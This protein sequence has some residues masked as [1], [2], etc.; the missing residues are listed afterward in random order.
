MDYKIEAGYRVCLAE[1]DPKERRIAEMFN[2]VAGRYDALNTVLS[3]GLD[4]SWRSYLISKISPQ[5]KGVYLDGAT[6]TGDLLFG[7]LQERG[8]LFRRY[9]GVDIAPIMLSQAEKKAKARALV[10]ITLEFAYMNLRHLAIQEESIACM[11]VAFGLR[12]TS[13]TEAVLRE[14]YRVLEPGGQLLILE[15][16]DMPPGLWKFFFNLYFQGV[17]PRIARFFAPVQPYRHLVR[18]VQAYGG[19]KAFEELLK[20]IGFEVM[21]SKHFSAGPCYFLEARKPGIIL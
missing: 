17:L 18:S 5:R 12:N 13:D 1:L 6:G 14:A 9:L 2:Q 15:F 10:G 21:E 11:S 7:L 16:F 20:K 8:S 3:L 4:R 19:V